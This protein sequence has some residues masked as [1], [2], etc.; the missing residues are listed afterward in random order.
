MKKYLNIGYVELDEYFNNEEAIAKYQQTKDLE[1]RNK[2]VEQNL[3]LVVR[4]AYE[5]S[6]PSNV[7]QRELIDEG[8]IAL[9]RAIDCYKVGEVKFSTYAAHSIIGA[10]LNYINKCYGEGSIYYGNLIKRYKKMAFEILGDSADVYS[11]EI[12]DYILGILVEEKE[13]PEKAVIGVKARLLSKSMYDIEDVENIEYEEEELDHTQFINE[14][15]EEMF[16]RLTDEKKEIII[17]RYIK[18]MD[19]EE[20]A[21]EKGVTLYHVYTRDKKALKKMRRIANKYL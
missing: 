2:I 5:Y 3:P 19:L 6:Y 8:S 4:L 20:V 18:N 15:K 13:I 14:H 12:V 10:L 11:E 9:M 21:K 17:S 16:N 7:N 1:L